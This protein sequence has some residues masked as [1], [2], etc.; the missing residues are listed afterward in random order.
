MKLKWEDSFFTHKHILQTYIQAHI[1]KHAHAISQP[2]NVENNE[3]KKG[4]SIK[5]S[6]A[7]N[8]AEQRESKIK[9]RDDE[10]KERNGKGRRR[11]KNIRVAPLLML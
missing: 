9:N 2:Q 10:R 11:G 5:D 7:T 6:P 8:E 1:G 3:K 4:Q